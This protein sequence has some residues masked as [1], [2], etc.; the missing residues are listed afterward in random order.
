[1][2]NYYT[3][4]IITSKLFDAKNNSLKTVTVKRGE[5]GTV[6]PGGY[7]LGVQFINGKNESFPLYSYYNV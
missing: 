1:M 6:T 3:I 2:E 4:G 7:F 5:K